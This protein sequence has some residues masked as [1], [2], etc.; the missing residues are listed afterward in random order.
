MYV[1]R[2]IS[3]RFLASFLVKV[4]SM[5]VCVANLKLQVTRH[6]CPAHTYIYTHTHANNKFISFCHVASIWFIF[7]RRFIAAARYSYYIAN[8]ICCCG[9]CCHLPLLCWKWSSVCISV[10]SCE[11]QVLTLK[12]KFRILVKLMVSYWLIF[13]FEKSCA[14]KCRSLKFHSLI[15]KYMCNSHP[16]NCVYKSVIFF[17]WALHTLLQ[18]L[19][20]ISNMYLR[21]FQWRAMVSITIVSSII[22]EKTR[23]VFWLSASLNSRA[24]EL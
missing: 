3:L 2:Y 23:I 13:F 16:C 15:A 7:A 8:I 18:K 11:N 21:Y 22:S 17:L 5:Y 24:A 19:D 10:M 4:I 12:A 1:C 6:R 14:W 20:R 9:C